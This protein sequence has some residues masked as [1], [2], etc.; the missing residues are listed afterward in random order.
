MRASRERKEALVQE[1]GALA[2]LV[3]TMLSRH[4]TQWLNEAQL[5]DLVREVI[6]SRRL[7]ARINRENRRAVA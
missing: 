1:S 2:R 4:G 3:G 7:S 6:A 5:D